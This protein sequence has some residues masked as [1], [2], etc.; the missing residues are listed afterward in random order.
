MV[1]PMRTYKIICLLILLA[2]FTMALSAQDSI[3]IFL[4]DIELENVPAREIGG[5]IMLP[6]AEVFE[7]LEAEFS[8]HINNKRVTLFVMTDTFKSINLVLDSPYMNFS[9]DCL[10]Q[11]KPFY[12]PRFVL[13]PEGNITKEGLNNIIVLSSPAKKVDDTYFVPLDAISDEIFEHTALFSETENRVNIT[14]SAPKAVAD[15]EKEEREEFEIA[16]GGSYSKVYAFP[17]S[18]TYL[19]YKYNYNNTT[20]SWIIA[21]TKFD[22]KSDKIWVKNISKLITQDIKL[23]VMPDVNFITISDGKFLALTDFRLI[24]FDANC[25]VEWECGLT[26]NTQRQI[27]TTETGDII[28]LEKFQTGE[29]NFSGST[30]ISYREGAKIVITKVNKDG[31]IVTQ[32]ALGGSGEVILNKAMYDAK[33][34]LI[35][36]GTTKSLNGDFI[37]AAGDIES[38]FVASIDLE[39]FDVKFIFENTEKDKTIDSDL[40]NDDFTVFDGMIYI[41]FSHFDKNIHKRVLS[42]AQATSEGEENWR[43]ALNDMFALQPSIYAANDGIIAVKDGHSTQVFSFDQ[44]GN[45]LNNTTISGYCRDIVFTDDGGFIVVQ[46]SIGRQLSTPMYISSIWYDSITTATKYDKNFEMVWTKTYNSY[47]DDMVV[48]ISG[49]GGGK[50]IV[51]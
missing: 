47:T 6:A 46:T 39:S 48:P 27:L 23:G 38:D 11:E 36:S 43:T 13:S 28:L 41:I 8:T 42:L 24:K 1:I 40:R 7:A 26:Y 12:E 2:V 4:N 25:N 33:A 51:E 14:R 19:A 5:N 15:S 49:L 3:K 30:N 31:K 35:I 37:K 20:R 50:L 16:L 21:L 10:T 34:G 44:K 18:E 9:T 45:I 17:N 22:E 32:K 29:L